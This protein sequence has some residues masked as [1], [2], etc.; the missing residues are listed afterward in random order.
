MSFKEQLA[1][2]RS[3]LRELRKAIPETFA[4]FVEMEKAASAEGALNHKEKEFVALGIGIAIRCD[5]CIL[6]HVNA[7]VRLGV[8]RE[9]IAEVCG[10]A[11]QMGGGPGLMYAAKALAAYDEFVSEG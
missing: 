9:E 6:S 3:E 8:T 2:K 10:V 1:G 11:V 4:G 7:L 5:A